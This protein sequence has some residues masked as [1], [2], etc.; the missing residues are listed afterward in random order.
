MATIITH[1]IAA[2]A[3]G[4]AFSPRVVPRLVWVSGGV[5]AMIPDLDIC[6]MAFDSKYAD[7]WGHR[8]FTH[9][10]CFA[11]ILALCFTYTILFRRENKPMIAF[12]LFLA[13][14]SHGVLDA[15]T[16]GGLGIAFFS[17]FENSRYFFPF[18][19]LQVSEIGL[20]FYQFSA[21]K[22]LLIE[23][24]WVWLPSTIMIGFFCN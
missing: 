9:S 3:I 12:Y 13:T 23:A 1:A 5:C 19:P 6:G 21:I 11:A 16:N 2:V 10:I 15:M 22:V 24:L 14:A 18:T 20:D 4:S 17:P 7:F 8:G